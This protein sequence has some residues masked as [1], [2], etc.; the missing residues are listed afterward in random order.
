LLN[1]WPYLQTLPQDAQVKVLSYDTGRWEPLFIA[2][3]LDPYYSDTC[4]F[5][6]DGNE[7]RLG[8]K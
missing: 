1:L 5:D 3:E 6:V 2:A 7:L 8:E 4:W